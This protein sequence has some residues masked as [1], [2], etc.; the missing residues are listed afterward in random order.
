MALRPWEAQRTFGMN[1]EEVKAPVAITVA[2]R[3]Q[4]SV[5]VSWNRRLGREEG[6]V[7][8]LGENPQQLRDHVTI[9]RGDK[10]S[11]SIQLDELTAGKTYYV[12]IV[13]FRG[14]KR[15]ELVELW[16]V[17]PDIAGR[18]RPAEK[19]PVVPQEVVAS[20]IVNSAVQDVAKNVDAVAD[21]VSQSSATP[22]VAGQQ[23]AAICSACSGDV[24]LDSIEQ[25]FKCHGCNAA[26]VQRVADGR[27]LPV[28]VLT[29]GICSCC[30]PKRPLIQTPGEF[31]RC[32]QTNE[33]Y[34]EL[35]GNGLIKISSLDY[36][37]CNCCNPMVPL[38]LN[39]QGQIVCSRKRENLYVRDGRNFSLRLPEAP[40]S[41]LSDIDAALANGS[42]GML[43]NG[44][45]TTGGTRPRRGR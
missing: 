11:Y 32:S 31:K 1:A 45:L 8:L 5:V 36:G 25:V 12:T 41:L 7:V 13:A 3:S 23:P 40:P 34:V 20:V 10:T 16:K 38:I 22:Q 15:S 28:A 14:D 39:V 2:Q 29:N 18:F 30:T 6:F 44:I 37:L 19:V 26:Y 24:F 9:P 33:Q 4:T 42:A 35:P 27:F 43:P 21:V 17:I